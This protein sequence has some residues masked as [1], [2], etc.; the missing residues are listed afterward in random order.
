MSWWIGLV[1]RELEG[2]VRLALT[3]SVVLEFLHVVTDARRFE[4]PLSMAEAAE[5]VAEIW[6]S[7]DVDRIPAASRVVPR[8]LELLRR[9]R[10]G[11]QRI[12]DTALAATLESAGVRRLATWNPGDSRV[13]GFLE[14]VGE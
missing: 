4:V 10:L 12:H 2:E 6:N 9:H 7:P 11:R 13:S 3:T 5:V 1:E 14:L 8:T